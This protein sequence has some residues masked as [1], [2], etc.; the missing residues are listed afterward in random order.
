VHG[1]R[2]W[3]GAGTALVRDL[4][5]TLPW[6][7]AYD[8][9]DVLTIQLV[10]DKLMAKH[11]MATHATG[12][13]SASAHAVALSIFVAA[14]LRPSP[15]DAVSE[16][17]ML[18]QW[19]AAAGISLSVAPPQDEG[20]GET[21]AGC[22]AGR[23]ATDAGCEAADGSVG[24]DELLAVGWSIS[25]GAHAL[26]SVPAGRFV[27]APAA[28]IPSSACALSLC[29]GAHHSLAVQPSFP[30]AADRIELAVRA[31]FACDALLFPPTLVLSV[32]AAR[33]D[34][35]VNIDALNEKMGALFAV[36]MYAFSLGLCWADLRF[37]KPSGG[38]R[39]WR[40]PPPMRAT[41]KLEYAT[42]MACICGLVVAPSTARAM[43]MNTPM[44][45]FWASL[46]AYE[47]TKSAVHAAAGVWRHAEPRYA[48]E[49]TERW[50][51]RSQRAPAPVTLYRGP[52]LVNRASAVL[53]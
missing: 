4:P 3:S 36:P 19:L 10:L 20:R 37:G 16:G 9:R 46:T 23:G 5:H 25:H 39:G 41:G 51:L 2:G 24:G 30:V 6:L 33:A 34:T 31:L 44:R 15:G 18:G 48:L 49:L 21:N 45:L 17:Q 28:T 14:I 43:H 32:W 27:A 47:A 42:L 29:G 12:A 1:D 40:R 38:Q 26:V 22:E 35:H 8:R 52:Q 50:L 13:S 53:V 7:P 11:A